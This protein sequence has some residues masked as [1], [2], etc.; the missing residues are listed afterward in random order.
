MWHW[1]S[2]KSHFTQAPALI[3]L[4][5]SLPAAIQLGYNRILQLGSQQPPLRFRILSN[6][7]MWLPVRRWH[8]TVTLCGTKHTARR[9]TSIRRLVKFMLTFK[10]LLLSKTML[11]GTATLPTGKQFVMPVKPGPRLIQSETEFS[12]KFLKSSYRWTQPPN[13]CNQPLY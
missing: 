1:H 11:I 10:C 6:Y 5:E 13:F 4:T 3:G 9:F 12:A 2:H 8:S 7:R